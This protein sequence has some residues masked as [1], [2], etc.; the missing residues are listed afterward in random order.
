MRKRTGLH[1]LAATIVAATIATS[2]GAFDPAQTCRK[3]KNQLAGKYAQCR[4]KAEGALALS[5]DAA[6]YASALDRCATSFTQQWTRLET[7]TAAKPPYTCPTVDDVDTMSARIEA[8]TTNVATAL[9]GGPL[10]YCP[11]ALAA[12][13][14]SLDACL[15]AC[16]PASTL[17]ATGQTTCY[18]ATGA[19][20]ACAGT[21]QDGELQ[22]GHARSYV[23]NGDGTVTDALT[24]LTWEQLT[25]DGSI[26]DWDDRYGFDDATSVKIPTLDTPPC[27]AG[28]CDW[29]IP[30]VIELQTLLDYGRPDDSPAIS[31]PFDSGCVPGC[32][33]IACGCTPAAA[34]LT[35]SVYVPVPDSAYMWIVWFSPGTTVQGAFYGFDGVARAVRGGT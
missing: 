14:A 16:P 22:K 30:N 13:V 18:D 27:F 23:E 32:D 19:A 9:A 7:R 15:G 17:I 31:G 35:S 8:Y 2:A 34:T 1:R 11:D 20:V 28:H 4:Q 21:G 29:R 12:C 26:H 6:T 25:D 10:F 33:G 24:G 5:G 3:G